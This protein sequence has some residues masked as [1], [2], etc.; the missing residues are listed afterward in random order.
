MVALDHTLVGGGVH[1]L[2]VVVEVADETERAVERGAPAC[3]EASDGGAAHGVDDAHAYDAHAGG[4]A[5]HE[6]QE[7][8]AVEKGDDRDRDRRRVDV[9]VQRSQGIREHDAQDDRVDEV[10]EHAPPVAREGS[11]RREGGVGRRRHRPEP[12]E[13]TVGRFTA[14]GTGQLAGLYEGSALVAIGHV[15]PQRTFR[16]R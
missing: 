5:R 14:L 3:F 15:P 8:R 4:L 9:D 13:R 1:V 2:G 10:A 12:G 6:G 16:H 11:G 7:E